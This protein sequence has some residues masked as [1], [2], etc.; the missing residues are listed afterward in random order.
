M[1][2]ICPDCRYSV[3]C[4]EYNEG[5][6]MWGLVRSFLVVKGNLC[7]QGPGGEKLFE[8]RIWGTFSFLV[9]TKI[10]VY[11]QYTGMSIHHHI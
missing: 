7:Y 3:Y 8:G 2:G 5:P 1:L 9:K 4:R 6:C 10:E 11:K